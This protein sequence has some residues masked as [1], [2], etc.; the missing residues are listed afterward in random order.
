MSATTT[1]YQKGGRY[2][3][4]DDA[5]TPGGT[6]AELVLHSHLRVNTHN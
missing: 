2:V 5:S 6:L 3:L 1:G 4:V